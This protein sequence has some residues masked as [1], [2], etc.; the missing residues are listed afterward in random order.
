MSISVCLSVCLSARVS[1]KHTSTPLSV[2]EFNMQSA[3]LIATAWCL[4]VCAGV[5]HAVGAAATR[6]DEGRGPQ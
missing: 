6:Q 4:C 5:Q 2:Q 1:Q 3:V